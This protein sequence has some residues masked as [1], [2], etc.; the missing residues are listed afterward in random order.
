MVRLSVALLL[1]LVPV[2]MEA[3]R[4]EFGNFSILAA[5]L[6]AFSLVTFG[7]AYFALARRAKAKCTT[8]GDGKTTYTLTDETIEAKSLLGSMALVWSAVT[9]VRRYRDLV[10]VGFRGAGYSTIPA[11]QISEEA[12]KF[13]VE[14]AR[15]AGAKITGF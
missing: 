2:I 4:G 10:L 3:K 8:I 5:T 9:E 14:R 7:A 6:V 15:A 1:L 11:A 12:L 13:L